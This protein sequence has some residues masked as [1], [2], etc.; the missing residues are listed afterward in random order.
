M[1]L[2]IIQ[3]N[4]QKSKNVA[5]DLKNKVGKEIDL[6]VLQ[7]PYAFKGKVKGYSSLQTRVLQPNVSNPQ[8][9]I[10]IYNNDIDVMQISAENSEHIIVAQ[11]MIRG[12]ELF[13]ISIYFQ[14]SHEVEPYLALLDKI[15]RKL[16][17]KKIL[18]C[19]DVNANSTHWFSKYTDQ[20]GEKVYDFIIENGLVLLNEPNNSPTYS[21]VLGESNIDISLSSNVNRNKIKWKVL[22]NYTFSDHNVILIELSFN[23]LEPRNLIKREAVF[24]IKKADWDDF[25]KQITEKFCTDFKL[26]L[27]ELHADR[28]VKRIIKTI[29]RIC[30]ICIPKKQNDITRSVPWWSEKLKIIRNEMMKNRKELC[31]CKKLNLDVETEVAHLRYRDSRKKYVNEI[32]K[33]KKQSWQNFVKN[34]GNKDPWGVVYKILR[35]KTL[36]RNIFYATKHGEHEA[37]TW[38]GSVKQILQ[39][40]VPNTESCFNAVKEKSEYSNSNVENKI[41]VEEIETAV[42]MVKLNKAPGQ[43]KL[44]PEIIKQIWKIDKDIYYILFNKCFEAGIFPNIWKEAIVKLILKAPDRDPHDVSSYRPIALLPV[45]GKVYERVLINRIQ[46]MYIDQKLNSN[47]QFGFKKCNS[48]DDALQRVVS[49]S[50]HAELKYTINIFV[51]IQGAF[52]NICWHGILKRLENIGCSSHLIRIMKNYFTKRNMKVKTKNQEISKEMVRGCP[53]GSVVGPYVW[54][55]C[56]DELLYKLEEME[57]EEIYTTA[58]ADDLAIIISANS[59]KD[60]ESKSG[61]AIKILLEWCKDYKLNISVKKTK[62][63][64]TKGNF[65]KERMPN[66]KI[67]DTKVQFVQ[68]YK[69]LGVIID[70]RLNFTKHT[71]YLRNKILNLSHLIAK[72][73]KEDWGLNTKNLNILYKSLYLP[74]ITY[75][76]IAWYGKVNH[77]HVDRNLSAIH[78]RLLV[79][80]TKS[81]RTTSTSAM[82]VI[83]GHM[84]LKFEII[85]R[86]ILFK[87]SRKQ[88]VQWSTYRFIPPEDPNSAIDIKEEH[89]KIIKEIHC[90]W[91]RQWSENKHG[92]QTEKFLPE[93][94]NTQNKKWYKL[95][96]QMTYILTGYGPINDSLYTRGSIDSPECPC[97]EA[98]NETVEHILFDCPVYDNLRYET[99]KCIENKTRLHKLIYTEAEFN[100]LKTY[101]IETFKTRDMHI[102]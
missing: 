63:M 28:A 15:I 32:R 39:K 14:Y 16:G 83:A 73:T 26:T 27:L 19:A 7:E 79:G 94:S 17:N 5:A 48:T 18:I 65:D 10:I 49:K 98:P 46:Q 72:T 67:G 69:Y 4:A 52:D 47:I 88:H 31:R 77:S 92:R 53:Q 36:N 102:R 66:I 71:K 1:E 38:E 20:K 89:A 82:E 21:T 68:E 97:C 99:L 54:T 76:A 3:L 11:L 24:N 40:I 74:I 41:S 96:R 84:P 30:E 42:N 45:I 43:D 61:K 87:I 64:L 22:P 60:L 93:V 23:N 85:K 57:S 55:W 50:K 56:M 59:R 81:C 2:K 78:R 12:D 62:A 100:K 33:S 51:D 75:G 90:I 44:N 6:I 91:Q 86:A 101:L 35:N 25:K 80:M 8:V 70:H 58:F 34:I 37:V 95:T 13:V 9:A 29:Y